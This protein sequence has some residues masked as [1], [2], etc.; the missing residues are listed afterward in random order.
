LNCDFDLKSPDFILISN[1][2]EKQKLFGDHVSIFGRLKR[3][4]VQMT[5]PRI[6]PRVIARRDHARRGG[7][8]EL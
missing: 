5:R 6:W 7:H 3:Y 8:G 4:A 1:R 2:R